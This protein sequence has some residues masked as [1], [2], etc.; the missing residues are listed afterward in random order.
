MK[1]EFVLFN[2]DFWVFEEDVFE[3]V[4]LVIYGLILEEI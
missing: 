1:F 4:N 3:I 2:F